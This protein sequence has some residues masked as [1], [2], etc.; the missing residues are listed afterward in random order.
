MHEGL[1]PLRDNQDGL[2]RVEAFE[3]GLGGRMN[4]IW[5]SGETHG[6]RR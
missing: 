2:H 5:M 3:L 6:G 1:L 4:G